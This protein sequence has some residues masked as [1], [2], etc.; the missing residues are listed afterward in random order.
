MARQPF[1]I[2]PWQPA[3]GALRAMLGVAVAITVLGGLLVQGAAW[4]GLQVATAL[5]SYAVVAATVVLAAAWHLKGMNFGLANQVTLLRTGL[6][7]L[8]AGALLAAADGAYVSWS[9]AGVVG[10]ALS[11]DAV[12]GWLARRLGLASPF[13]ARFDLEIDALLILILALLVWQSGRA[14][15]WVLAIG[16]M[17][18]G[19]VAL[20]MIWPPGRRPLP[21]RWRRKAVCALIGI[22]LLVAIL[23]PTPLWLAGAAAAL[24]L[25]SQLASFAIDLAW[26]GGLRGTASAEPA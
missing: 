15:V 25:L 8:V 6:A 3:P 19:F 10:L 9:V 1:A 12:D 11:L 17:R 23:P 26:L 13:G 7:C 24:A 4:R 22:L 2:T 5:A 18:Y 21:P 20:G 16:G 14:G